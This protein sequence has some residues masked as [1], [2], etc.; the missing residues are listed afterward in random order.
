MHRKSPSHLSPSGL[1]SPAHTPHSYDKSTLIEALKTDCFYI[2]A[3]GSKKT[4]GSRL[5][6]LKEA[7][8]DPELFARIHGPIGLDIGAKSPAEIAIA[9]LGEM[10]SAL[11]GGNAKGKSQD[12]KAGDAAA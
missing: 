4:H 2:G 6:R 12:R 11:R 10:T 7:G 9:I 3:L 5:E 1:L 8:V